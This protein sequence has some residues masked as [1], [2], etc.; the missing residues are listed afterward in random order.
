[1]KK[2]HGLGTNSASVENLQKMVGEMVSGSAPPTRLRGVLSISGGNDVEK[3]LDE[4]KDSFGR[5]IQS[6]FEQEG[7]TN[8]AENLQKMGREM[9]SVQEMVGETVSASRK[10][11]EARQREQE[12]ERKETGERTWDSARGRRREYVSRYPP[13]PVNR[14][15]ANGR[16]AGAKSPGRVDTRPCE[17][18]IRESPPPSAD[19]LRELSP[20]VVWTPDS[21]RRRYENFC[22]NMEALEALEERYCPAPP[23]RAAPADQRVV[24]ASP[25]L[26]VAAAAAR[27]S[28][29]TVPPSASRAPRPTP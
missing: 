1:M 19:V 15:E 28:T 5:K 14:V 2:E 4:R 21:A 9:V 13:S 24:A 16:A 12:R 27:R 10:W 25:A 26:P 23:P 11:G 20:R 6:Q 29:T 18:A 22:T 7:G 3:T 8:S 17:A